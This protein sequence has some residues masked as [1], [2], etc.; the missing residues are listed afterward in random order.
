[1]WLLP[2]PGANVEEMTMN[3]QQP[4]RTR[5]C[6]SGLAVLLSCVLGAP[7]LQAQ[8]GFD[9]DLAGAT[10]SA[11]LELLLQKYPDKG[12]VLVPKLES[13][14]ID[15]IRSAGVGNRFVLKD[16]PPSA[17]KM[18]LFVQSGD[19][20]GSFDAGDPDEQIA[21]TLF[22]ADEILEQNKNAD[23]M[24]RIALEAMRDRL[25]F[26]GEFPGDKES[27]RTV[28][29]SRT[30]RRPLADGSVHR[31]MGRVVM[32]QYSFLSEG[33][34]TARLTFGVVRNAGY[35]YLRGKGTVALPDGTSVKL[36]Y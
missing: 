23:F 17:L 10:T 19:K 16:L 7:G 35:V 1:V 27:S 3:L 11:Q 21:V 29:G 18:A 34:K 24:T 36:G 33:P 5:G 9:A 15:E 25:L 30:P 22:S 8:G 4:L 12:D 26:A 2:G 14:M 6:L 28:A 31:I 32:G 13:V 20:F